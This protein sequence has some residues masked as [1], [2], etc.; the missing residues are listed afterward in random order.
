MKSDMWRR[1]IAVGLSLGPCGA[2]SAAVSVP[3]TLVPL[4]NGGQVSLVVSNTDPNL[5][6]VAGDRVIAINSLD[7]EAVIH[8][9]D[10]TNARV[11][12]MSQ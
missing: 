10:M 4:N 1:C 8:T 9:A 3:P 6:R 7:G 11:R 12:E 2:F 5:L